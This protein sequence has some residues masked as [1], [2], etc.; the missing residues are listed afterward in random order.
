MKIKTITFTKI[1][2]M[3]IQ[4]L[5]KVKSYT[6]SLVLL[7]FLSLGSHGSVVLG[8]VVCELLV[9]RLGE[10]CLLPQVRRQVCVGVCDGS[11]GCLG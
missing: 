3:F 10:N 1:L 8:Q 11:I 7:D 6:R 5:S 9:R 4:K 2:L